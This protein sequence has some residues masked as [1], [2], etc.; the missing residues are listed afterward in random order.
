MQLI[1][2]DIGVILS[3]A[4]RI[5][6]PVAVTMGPSGRTVL[7]S[8][9]HKPPHLT[10]DGVS[11]AT[12]I[13]GNNHIEHSTIH[14]FQ[15]MAKDTVRET[16]DGTTTSIVL[17]Y[18]ILTKGFKRLN[19]GGNPI[20]MQRGMLLM[21]ENIIDELQ[22]MTI[23]VTSSDMLIN[24]ATI[25]SNNDPVMGELVSKA[26]NEAGK[27]GLVNVV[28]G[29][30]STDEIK[31][32]DG[33][34]FDKGYKST[35]FLGSSDSI[36]IEYKRPLVFISTDRIDEYKNIENVIAICNNLRR[37]M[38][39]ICDGMSQIVLNQVVK[40]KMDHQLD[41]VVIDLPG[42]SNRRKDW[43]EDI[44]V[45]CNGRVHS[46]IHKGVTDVIS[47]DSLGE[48]DEIRVSSLKTSMV[49]GLMNKTLINR[50]V[51][52]LRETL[53]SD[54]NYD[55]S[56]F[57]ERIAKLKGKLVT[58]SVGGGGEVEVSER[59]DRID[60]ALGS[61]LTS[62]KHGVVIG[63]G[64]S[65]LKIADKLNAKDLKGI[66]TKLGAEI[67]LNSIRAPFETILKNAG[68]KGTI[69]YQIELNIL[70]SKSEH[71]GYNVYTNEYGNMVDMGVIDPVMVTITALKHAVSTASSLLTASYVIA[72]DII[73]KRF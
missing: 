35:Y 68:K 52:K 17:A 44:A 62:T 16:G 63:G 14:I 34:T 20:E 26:V 25:A 47:M 43:A 1:T 27:Y 49:G 33:V 64:N 30:T 9:I 10:K 40:L 24:V 69:A 6:D 55:K 73:E 57:D 56:I 54:S 67:L 58:I 4:K 65:L 70:S 71:Y 41:L 37:P 60:D 51:A 8:Q 13:K 46:S 45:V 32:T 31:V 48:L 11:V 3:G 61:V 12:C 29:T 19:K 2:N 53:D 21:V 36:T 23:P 72:D 18:N 39:I 15:E 5:H 38:V 42:W 28:K 59:K 66:G 50:H 22:K 7:C